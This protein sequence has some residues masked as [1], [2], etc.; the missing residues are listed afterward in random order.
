[1]FKAKIYGAGSI[2]AHYANALVNNGFEVDIFDISKDALLRFK[3]KIYPIRYKFFSDKITILEKDIDKKYDLVIIGTPPISHYKIVE[4]NLK[5]DVKII[6][7]E[8]PLCSSFNR[9]IENFKKLKLYKK[10]LISVGYNHV[11][12]EVCKKSLEILKKNKFGK[13]QY[14]ESETKEHWDNIFN[15]HFWLKKVNDSYLGNSKFGG[16]ALHEHSHALHLAHFFLKKINSKDEFKKV[17]CQMQFKSGRN[18]YYDSL[19]KLE[20]ITKKN[21]LISIH[22]DLVSKKSSKKLHLEFEKGYLT[23]FI[24]YKSNLDLIKYKLNNKIENQIKFKKK[25]SDDF[26]GTVNNY[27][28]YLAKTKFNKDLNLNDSLKIMKTIQ[29]SFLSNKKRKIISIK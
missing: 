25:R 22:Q 15:A 17:F 5:R 29:A 18:Y 27:K 10:T 8:K 13:I 14:I 23:L 11:L 12:T 1:M 19:S 4:K 9:D 21:I 26:L 6:H 24:N 16:G 3:K 28:R 2:G 7:I 20:I